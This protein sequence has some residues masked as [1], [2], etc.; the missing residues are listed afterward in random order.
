MQITLG[1]HNLQVREEDN[2][3]TKR[4]LLDHDTKEPNPEQGHTTQSA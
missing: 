3:Q 2:D 1:D 4:Q